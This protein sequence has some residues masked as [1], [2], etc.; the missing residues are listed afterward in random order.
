MANLHP[1]NTYNQYKIRVA[2]YNETGSVFCITIPRHI[3]ERF[4]QAKFSVEVI[5]NSI[6]FMSGQDIS[7]LKKEIKRYNLE[8]I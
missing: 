5:N 6:V 3:A 1:Q 7:Q 4:P 2:S 8:N